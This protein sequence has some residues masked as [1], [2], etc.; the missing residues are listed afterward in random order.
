MAKYSYEFKMKVV[1]EYLQGK[2][3]D[4]VKQCSQK[5]STSEGD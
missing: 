5:P 1:N 3:G 2:L 4:S